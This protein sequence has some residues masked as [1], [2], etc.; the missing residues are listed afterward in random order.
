MPTWQRRPCRADLH[1]KDL[2][3][4]RSDEPPADYSI[5]MELDAVDALAESLG[6]DRFHLI[7]YSGGGMMSVAYAGT[8]PDRLLSLGLFEAARV[9][10]QLT[11]AERDFFD[12]LN[13]KLSGLQGPDFM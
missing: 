1:L 4:Y 3:L 8:R 7:G 13:K 9:P 11:S 5:D 12:Q 6:L 2:E 10:G